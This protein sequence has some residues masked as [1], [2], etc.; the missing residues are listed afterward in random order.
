[1]SGR[2]KI[3][4]VD[5]RPANL[6]AL[7]AILGSLDQTL[8]RAGSGEDALRALL[9]DDFA[10]ILLDAQMPGMDGFET[11]TRI[12]ARERTKNVPIIFLTAN[13]FDTH[14]A[15]RGYTTG[16]ADFLAKPFDPWLLRAKVQVFVD[17]WHASRKLSAQADLLR[18]SLDERR[19]ALGRADV[20]VVTDLRA[21]VAS[22]E[23]AVA[24]LDSGADMGPGGDARRRLGQRLDDLRR[25]VDALE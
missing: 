8:V 6:V 14:L 12:K 11:A 7:E 22:V 25:A 23:E 2:A 5:D 16:A 15:Y 13:D 1:M 10:L 21:R 4:L 24:D 3:L 18:R 19:G 17:L 9:H 20:D